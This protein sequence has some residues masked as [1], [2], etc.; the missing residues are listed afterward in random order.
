MDRGEEK[1]IDQDLSIEKGAV[2]IVYGFNKGY[3][4]TFLKG[5]CEH[6]K[7]DITVPYS[8]LE[9]YQKKA[10]L[11]GNIDEVEFMW[12][13]HK[14][15]RLFPGIIRIA[16]DMF[17]DEKELADYMSEKVCSVC[18]SH[19]L[20]RESLAVRVGDIGIAELLDMP[21]NKTY[22]DEVRVIARVRHKEGRKRNVNVTA[23]VHEIKVFEGEFKTVVT[24]RHILKLKLLNDS[25]EQ[26]I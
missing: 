22:E 26:E 8:E 6:N 12:K 3:Y 15:K 16:Y 13:N 5:F 21:I 24:E 18:G 2:K 23:F 11:H 1:I 20:K 14:V 4:F 10:I 25:E 19:R 9:E 17:K 7:I